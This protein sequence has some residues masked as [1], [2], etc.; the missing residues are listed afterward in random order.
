[1]SSGLF[2]AFGAF[3]LAPT[4]DL[5][6]EWVLPDIIHPISFRCI[7]QKTETYITWVPVL[8][9]HRRSPFKRIPCFW[10]LGQLK[11]AT[12]PGLIL[13]AKDRRPASGNVHVSSVSDG[14]VLKIGQASRQ[15]ADF[16]LAVKC[17]GFLV[18]QLP[19]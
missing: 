13:F 15:T 11:T 19:I 18:L 17:C 3:G 8:A 9:T 12:G 7:S 1:M 16:H 6:F 10:R 14:F 5:W 4:L 2:G